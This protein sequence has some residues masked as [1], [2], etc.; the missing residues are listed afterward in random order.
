[1]DAR[2]VLRRLD[3]E[4]RTLALDGT[5][6]DVLPSVTRL[7]ATDGSHHT[8]IYSRLSAS[9]ADEAIAREV[10]HHRALGV[11]FEWK[12][13]AHD[14]PADLL[15]RLRRHG[16]EIGP[17]EAALAFDLNELPEW[18]SDGSDVLVRRG[19]DPGVIADYRRVAEAAFGKD[20]SFTTNQL[21]DALRAGSTRH[22]GYVAYAPDD[23]SPASIG[24][25]HTHPASA[26]GGL[27]G[28][29]TLPAYRGRGY[30]RATVAARARDAIALGARYLIVDALPTSRPILERLGFRHLTDTWPCE[31]RP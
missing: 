25:L 3:E 24:R 11:P 7:H 30:Y 4:R 15:E 13:Y 22:R 28:G 26:F 9:D 12:V 27:Y 5:T 19:D 21:L 1:V 29:A 23:G 14:G 6:L 16:F 31:W 10:A 8:V 17:V 18:I 20:Y 2:E